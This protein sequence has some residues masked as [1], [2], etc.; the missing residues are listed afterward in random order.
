MDKSRN[1]CPKA[2]RAEALMGI[3]IP[4]FMA[5]LQLPKGRRQPSVHKKING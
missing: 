4:V 3:W 1:S 2:L 5:H